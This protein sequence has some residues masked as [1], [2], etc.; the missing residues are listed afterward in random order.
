[1]EGPRAKHRQE[2]QRDDQGADQREDHRVGHRREE[3]AR[4]PLKNVDRQE[5]R[6]DHR[7]GIENRAVHF[8][9]GVRNDFHDLEWLAV[10]R[11]DPAVDVLH[12]HYRAVHQDAKVHRADR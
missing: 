4:R 2:R 5:G 6:D 10:A 11:G 7:D 9:G 3:L 12:H 8:G 1:M